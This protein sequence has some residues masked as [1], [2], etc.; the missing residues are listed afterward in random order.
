MLFYV[1]LHGSY[2]YRQNWK[3]VCQDDGH[4]VICIKLEKQVIEDGILKMAPGLM[5]VTGCCQRQ[6]C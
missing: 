2:D 6:D 5:Y 3:K 4:G 1:F